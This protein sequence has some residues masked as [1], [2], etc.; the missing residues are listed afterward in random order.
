MVGKIAKWLGPAMVVGLHGQSNVWVTYGGKCYLVAQ[1]HCRQ[2]IGEEALVG[3]PEVQEALRIFRENQIGDSGEF[4]DLTG[5]PKPTEQ[6]L[7]NPLGD[8]DDQ[9]MLGDERDEG[10]NG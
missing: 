9:M 8:D 5:D 4:L 6:D 3:R 1:E 7:D 2:A 10:K